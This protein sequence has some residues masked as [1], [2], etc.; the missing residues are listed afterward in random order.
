MEMPGSSQMNECGECTSNN[1][2]SNQ[3]LVAA[4]LRVAWTA[5]ACRKIAAALSG[6]TIMVMESFIFDLT[7]VPASWPKKKA[8][9]ANELIA[10]MKTARE[11]YGAG[12]IAAV[13]CVCGRSVSSP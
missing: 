7:T 3:K 5:S 10:F 9:Q 2:S 4:C 12:W 1:G 11:I 13:W 6:Y 8:F